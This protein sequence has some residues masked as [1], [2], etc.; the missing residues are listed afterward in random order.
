MLDRLDD[1][2]EKSGITVENLSAL[3]YAGEVTGTSFESLGGG[4]T[5]L[6][7]NMAEAAGGGKEAAAAFKAVGIEVTNGAGGLRS[8][9]EILGE[10]ADR[11]A[12]YEDGA[13]KAALAQKI[14]GKSGEE[15]IPLLNLGSEG[16]ARLRKE[17]AG[18]GAVYGSEV[19]K[20]AA[21][22]NDNLK[23]LELNA[24]ATKVSLASG[25]LPTLNDLLETFLKL[26]S[27][28]QV[29]TVIEEGIKRVVSL[30]PGLSALQMAAEKLGLMRGASLTGNPGQDINKLLGERSALQ[31]KQREAQAFASRVES[32]KFVS[33]LDRRLAANKRGESDSIQRDIFKIDDL[34]EV[35]RIRQATDALRDNGDTSD[36][37]TRRRRL[38][39]A[40]T[41]APVVS[42]GSGA[43]AANKEL[44]EQAKLVLELAGLT[45]TFTED[46]NR[47]NTMYAKGTI[48]L[49]TL[50]AE[51][52][53]LL[54][55]QPAIKAQLEL[56]Q[57]IGEARAKNAEITQKH[58]EALAADN[59][60]LVKS[61]Q[62]LREQNEEIGLSAEAIN[63]LRMARLDANIA[64]EEELLLIAQGVEGNEAE[65]AQLERKINLLRQERLINGDSAQKEI[66]AT[67]AE[68]AKRRTQTISESI[69]DGV[70]D[71]FRNSKSFSDVF[72]SELKAQFSKAILQ[73]VISPIVQMGQDAMSGAMKG[74][75]GGPSIADL[76]GLAGSFFG[77]GDTTALATGD[78]ARMD[79]LMSFDGGGST[80][81]GLRAGGIDGKGGFMAI[82]HPDETVTDH[83]KG[84]KVGGTV[85]NNYSFGAGVS[86]A[87]AYEGYRRARAE[88]VGDVVE[89]N[90]RRRFG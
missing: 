65:V 1:L 55:L 20:Q 41:Q 59:E 4:L 11:F 46:W 72:L 8:Q 10:L 56:E 79:R 80:G 36:A 29:W 50:T 19:A 27:A 12:G 39:T 57:K 66:L 53:K 87:E 76:F 15:M 83:T 35:S 34:L 14:F 47:L 18:L 48:N 21:E 42:D 64:R 81:P 86:R 25:L 62:A 32:Q 90:R 44:K 23:K 9:D 43:A 85:I 16:I 74:L 7:K 28:G 17:A 52:A 63:L 89:G 60:Q 24:E 49:K 2:S 84:Q 58:L 13:A 75:G 26:K 30:V 37:L 51:Q 38:A 40:K 45:G 77:A 67:E 31:D 5:K 78:F 70:L 88:A 54:S 33:Q 82:L 3:R 71:G 69:S 22:F 6:S 73:P 68:D 61:N